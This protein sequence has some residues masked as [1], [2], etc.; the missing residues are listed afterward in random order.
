MSGGEHFESAYAMAEVL[1]GAG[2]R[3]GAERELRRWGGPDVRP[4]PRRVAA[5][6]LAPLLASQGRGR[7][8]R[9]GHLAEVPA[10]AA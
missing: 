7:E 6:V 8:G 5:E 4:G 3:A 9:A 2:D 10:R 1:F